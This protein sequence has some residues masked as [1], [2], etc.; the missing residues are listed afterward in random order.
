MSGNHRICFIPGISR[1]LGLEP[2]RDHLSPTERGASVSRV[3]TKDPAHAL[4]QE[5]RLYRKLEHEIKEFSCDAAIVS[6]GDQ[7]GFNSGS[8][9]T[10]GRRL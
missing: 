10:C 9:I 7:L 6:G 5:A 4:W 2:D 8:A 1:G 3:I